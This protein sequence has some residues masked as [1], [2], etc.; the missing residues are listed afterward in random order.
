MKFGMIG[1]GTVSQAIAGHV[2]KAGYEVVL[3]T[4]ADR[5]PWVLWSMHSVQTHRLAPLPK[6]GQRTS[7]YLP[8]TGRRFVTRCATCPPAT[9]GSLLI[10]PTSG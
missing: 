4:A 8:C 10:P 7:L 6:Q 5:K 9:A 1:A 3:A 2:V